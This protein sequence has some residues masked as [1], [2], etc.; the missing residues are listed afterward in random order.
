MPTL[1]AVHSRVNC[2]IIKNQLFPLVIQRISDFDQNSPDS[3]LRLDHSKRMIR[4]QNTLLAYT[5]VFRLFF[6][7]FSFYTISKILSSFSTDQFSKM[8]VYKL[9][10]TYSQL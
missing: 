4:S 10:L 6:I 7:L 9:Y 2:Q 8:F 1:A 3:V 5:S